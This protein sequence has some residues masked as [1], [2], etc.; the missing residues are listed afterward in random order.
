MTRFSRLFLQHLRTCLPDFTSIRLV[1]FIGCWL[2]SLPTLLAQSA[3]IDGFAGPTDPVC[4]NMP[5]TFTA[6]IGNITGVYQYTITNGLDAPISGSAVTTDFSALLM[7]SQNGYYP[8][9][10]L[11]ISTSNGE[12]SAS[13]GF[14]VNPGSYSLY[15]NTGHP[16]TVTP[17]AIAGCSSGQWAW[18]TGVTS[19]SIVV[20]NPTEGMVVTATCTAGGS[21]CPLQEQFYLHEN[22]APIIIDNGRKTC[23]G[24]PLS[25]TVSCPNGNSPIVF[26]YPGSP[27]IG[28]TTITDVTASSKKLTIEG[29]APVSGQYE[30]TYQ[31]ICYGNATPLSLSVVAAPVVTGASASGALSCSQTSV[32]LTT[33]ATNADSFTLLPS[34]QVNSTGAFIVTTASVYTILAGLS[35]VIGCVSSSVVAVST[36][37]GNTN[38]Q[39]SL[40]GS[41]SNIPALVT[42]TASLSGATAYVVT[43]PGGFSSVNTT[44]VF[45]VTEAGLYSLQV[46]NS[47]GCPLTATLVVPPGAPPL[48]PNSFTTTITIPCPQAGQPAGPGELAAIGTGSAFIFT[49][50]NGYVYSNVFR[51]RG[52]MPCQ[53]KTLLHPVPTRS[54]CMAVAVSL[55]PI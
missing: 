20:T 37:S 33:T 32:T 11:T 21:A 9:I 27:T 41:L 24:T 26:Q 51:H 50:P 45:V 36:N 43:G 15:F 40:S 22:I 16:L 23:L 18:S 8:A 6:T 12:V 52:R 29:N 14:N 44:G 49:G 2:L 19:A 4:I 53:G 28:F 48:V 17:I 25:V 38:V 31:L 55:A 54:R 13:V 1:T 46:R 10:T 39:F 30:H 7:F 42:L 34:N 3:T 5:A 35:G 47:V